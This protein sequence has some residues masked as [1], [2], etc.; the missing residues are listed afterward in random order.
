[1]LIYTGR[2][3]SMKFG[4]NSNIDLKLGSG[5]GVFSIQPHSIKIRIFIGQKKKKERFDRR[6][7]ARSSAIDYSAARGDFN[8]AR[9]KRPLR[10]GRRIFMN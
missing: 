6:N 4:L 3:R 7:R 2:K 10:N 5:K 1:M 8:F 9:A